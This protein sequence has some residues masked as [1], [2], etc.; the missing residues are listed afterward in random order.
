MFIILSDENVELS[1]Q[2]LSNLE[3]VKI[4][5]G[6]E[7]QCF[8]QYA[9]EQPRREQALSAWIYLE[10]MYTKDSLFSVQRRPLKHIYSE[11]QRIKDED[12]AFLAQLEKDSYVRWFLPTRKLVSSVSVV[13]QYRPEEIPVTIAAFRALNYTDPRL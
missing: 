7:N 11:K 8:E 2:T 1:G 6:K 10:K 12:A 4:I 13:A 9:R 3:T 5:K